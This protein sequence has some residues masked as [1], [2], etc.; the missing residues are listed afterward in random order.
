MEPGARR[1]GG[2]EEDDEREGERRQKP[3]QGKIKKCGFLLRMPNVQ[4]MYLWTL[5]IPWSPSWPFGLEYEVTKLCP[6]EA[7]KYTLQHMLSN[8]WISF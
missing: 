8:S 5:C 4:L 7:F 6:I 1:G 2:G 3:L